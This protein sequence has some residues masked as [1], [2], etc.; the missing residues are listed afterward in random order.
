MLI[1]HTGKLAS[2]AI[3]RELANFMDLS[4]EISL[5]SSDNENSI[6]N[7]EEKQ[8]S[9]VPSFKNNVESEVSLNNKS[10][11]DLKSALDSQKLKIASLENINREL[12]ELV[13]TYKEKLSYVENENSLHKST[14][15]NLNNTIEKQKAEIENI[16]ADVDSYNSVIKELQIK[17]A[18]REKVNL[19]DVELEAMIANEEM[20][21]ANNENMKNILHSLKAALDSRNEEIKNLKLSLDSEKMIEVSK[22]KEEI[23]NKKKEVSVLMQEVERLKTE[24]NENVIV[25]DKLLKEKSN[26]LHVEKKLQTQLNNIE[27]D[28]ETLNETIALLNTEIKD[29]EHC[30][31]KFI[32]DL[33]EKE[34]E[35][36]SVID[37]NEG[38]VRTLSQ[39]IT[40][41][42]EDIKI[43]DEM[44]ISLQQT[45]NRTQEYIDRVQSNI[46]KFNKI[47]VLFT[48]NL[49]EVPEK[50]SDLVSALNMLGDKLPSLETLVSDSIEQKKQVVALLEQRE[51]ELGVLQLHINDLDKVIDSFYEEYKNLANVDKD[52]INIKCSVESE[53]D[54][55]N[56]YANLKNKLNNLF[57]VIKSTQT[58]LMQTVED[59]EKELKKID[60]KCK[61]L[62]TELE[63]ESNQVTQC[64]QHID[65][66]TN[67]RDNLLQNILEKA[68]GLT[69]E[70][71][72]ENSMSCQFNSN[73][74]N[75]YEQIILTLEKIANHVSILN[76]ERETKYDNTESLLSEARREIKLLTEENMKLIQDIS[77]LG[78]SN[79]ALTN[80]IKIIQ[81]DGQTLAKLLQESNDLL[82]Q[83]KHNLLMKDNEIKNIETKTMDWKD[84]FKN[85]EVFMKEQIVLLEYE[86]SELKSKCSALELQNKQRHDNAKTK[87][88]WK[89]QS[90]YTEVYSPPSL[91]KICCDSIIDVISSNDDDKTISSETSIT[92]DLKNITSAMQ[93]CKCK[94]LMSDL[95]ALKTNNNKLKTRIEEL[96]NENANLLKDHEETQKE[97]QLLL[98]NTH[99]LQ[100]KV[101]N[102]RTNL[103]TLTA[104]TYAENRSLTSKVKF[105][106][107]H[108]NRFHLVC[109]RDIPDFKRQLQELLILLKSENLGKLNESIKRYSLPNALESVSLYSQFKNESTI[110]GDLLMLDTNV[111]LN[112]CDNTLISHDQTCFDV[113]QVCSYNEVACETNLAEL[114]K[115]NLSYPQ[116]KVQSLDEMKIV[117]TLESL[118][119]E[120]DKL[121]DVVDEYARNKKS[122]SLKDTQSSPIKINSN[123]K[124][125]SNNND[126]FETCDSC[127]RT[128]ETYKK[129]IDVMTKG[130]AELQAQKINIEG[131]YQNLAIEVASTKKDNCEKQNEI[132][133]LN[134]CLMKKCEELKTLQEEYDLLSNQ[135]FESISEVDHLK[136]EHDSLKEINNTLTDKFSQLEK[137]VDR[138]KSGDASEK[139]K[140]CTEC[141]VKDAII[142]TLNSK[143][144]NTHQKLDRSF[145]DSDSSSRYNKICTLQNELHAGKKDCI[146][147][148][149]QVTT[150]KNHLERSNLSM[151]HAMDLDVSMGDSHLCSFNQ[152]FDN[153]KSHYEKFSMPDIPEERS[154]DSH[155]IDKIACFNYYIEKTAADKESLTCDIKILDVMKMLY[156]Y[157]EN[158]HS[159]EIDNLNNKLRDLEESKTEIQMQLN[160][161]NLDQDEI[162][163]E[164]KEKD[165]Y[166]KLF[167]DVISHLRNNLAYIESLDSNN[168]LNNFSDKFLK[169]IDKELGL[170][171]TQI[172]E[173]AIQN[174]KETHVIELENKILEN[175]EI[176]KA[177]QEKT[178]ETE[179]LIEKLS[180]LKLELFEKENE[181]ELLQR[182][183]EKVHEI[184]K[185]VTLDI[186]QKEKKLKDQVIENYNKLVGCKAIQENIDVTLPTMEIIKIIFEN[187]LNASNNTEMLEK[188][189]QLLVLEVDELKKLL[190]VKEKELQTLRNEIEA[191]KKTIL[192]ISEKEHKL[193][194]QITVHENLEKTYKNKIE[195]SDSNLLRMI[196][197][198]SEFVSLLKTDISNKEVI[199]TS[200]ESKLSEVNSNIEDKDK[201]KELLHSSESL[202]KEIDRLKCINDVILNEKETYTKELEK[203]NALIKQHKIDFEKLTSDILTLK[204]TVKESS[205]VTKNLRL[206]S[207]RLLEENLSLQSQLQEKCKEYSRM[208]DNIKKH[209]KT[210][211]IQ[212]GIITR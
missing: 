197:N 140:E 123:E 161:V 127:K 4:R 7:I 43:K 129:E 128:E 87:E 78:S 192:D 174:V 96:E 98:E 130:L 151:T 63:K 124:L 117:E 45:E 199:I 92:N 33:K 205:E 148:K 170:T 185:A 53:N 68:T 203:A 186:V 212:S 187:I 110:D 109:Q 74:E 173:L 184:S 188:E 99:E 62:C 107:H 112:S 159:N 29:F 9:E 20:F 56:T 14:I 191:S 136:K 145:S 27:K 81:S 204:E 39:K 134:N 178:K 152:D 1:Y 8:V 55:L 193:H 105:L 72:I 120:N 85:L 143:V 175:V 122:K 28:K 183:K 137:E 70:C 115:C 5:V 182:Q 75:M 49:L 196:K 144:P 91:L 67:K 35:I 181:I 156:E 131:K 167:G 47:M 108:H 103:S 90:L 198:L 31:K 69:S 46:H 125:Q 26:L 86:N 10:I 32:S 104:T 73:P 60:A 190:D 82:N 19:S 41:L 116:I 165:R 36:K 11:L 201:I 158:K 142:K 154:L 202:Q 71:N 172:F 17:L 59:K 44:I 169:K 210:A 200:L 50:M 21:I 89:K 171:S 93:H 77:N 150:I 149:E 102:H 118:K 209:E 18:D 23:E 132:H 42:E 164:L 6:I 13:T 139:Q 135:V 206:E 138:L 189:K 106:Q 2:K 166:L 121:R 84:K 208:E 40:E 79:S 157:L 54:T 153:V 15:E 155:T 168:V 163:K 76:T 160:K 162:A 195:E 194:A 25:V 113:T 12:K 207:K 80:E 94:D 83:L 133:K 52:K 177:L 180:A 88:L 65:D 147:L 16:N 97:V 146:E 37:I 179:S 3:D 51:T 101:L 61:T 111:T 48:G 95:D 57:T 34:G 38:Q 64:M 24:S 58:Y 119:T 141:N 211:E 176:N 114:T 66:L 30:K 126:S 100:K 22:M